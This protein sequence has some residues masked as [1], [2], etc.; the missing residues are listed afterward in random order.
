MKWEKHSDVT[1]RLIVM[2][3]DCGWTLK[4]VRK[5]YCIHEYHIYNPEGVF[6][7]DECGVN[8]AMNAVEG[9]LSAEY[10]LAQSEK[11]NEAIKGLGEWQLKPVPSLDWR[12]DDSGLQCF[13]GWNKEKQCV[14][15]DVMTIDNEPVV[16]I[17]GNVRDLYKAIAHNYQGMS[18]E[19][20]AYVGYEIANCEAN[21][22][23]YVQG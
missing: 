3:S 21:K 13:I 10:K 17:E 8:A 23:N 1:G 20:L 22:S 2:K 19:H 12:P 4:Q 7:A 11:L 18:L 16:S 9:R 14:R 5:F 6:V 15:V